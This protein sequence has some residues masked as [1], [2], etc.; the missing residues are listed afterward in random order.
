MKRFTSPPVNVPTARLPVLLF[1][2]LLAGVARAEP[3]AAVT[4]FAL[5]PE[6]LITWPF[7]E[8]RAAE[9]VSLDDLRDASRKAAL[10]RIRQLPHLTTLKF[11]GCDLSGVDE[12]DPVSPTVKAVLIS[13]GK[14]SQGTI[15]WL[16]KHPSGATLV[17][18]CDVRNLQLD[19]GHFKWLTFDNCQLSRSAVVKLV[20]SATQ[21]TFKEVTLA[22]D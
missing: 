16:A 10:A 11:Y 13:G 2:L 17:I 14:V 5:S 3:K 15:R 1:T 9:T 6:S 12:N 21:V 18:G 8:I 20:K 7:E 4:N 22:D 19:L